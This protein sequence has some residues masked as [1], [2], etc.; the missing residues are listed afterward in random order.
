MMK[1]R[2]FLAVGA[3]GVAAMLGV[4]GAAV[5]APLGGSHTSAVAPDSLRTLAAKVGLHIG[6]AVNP[7]DLTHP[8]YTAI[9]A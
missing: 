1:V 9:V 5:A 3:A 8:D 6:T 4:T 2:H 7:Y